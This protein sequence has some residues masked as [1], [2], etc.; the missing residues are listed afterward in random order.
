MIY[1]DWHSYVNL[2]FSNPLSVQYHPLFASRLTQAA[3][4]LSQASKSTQINDNNNNNHKYL[5]IFI[6]TFF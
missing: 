2:P 1:I 4:F 6:Y 5:Y 3:L